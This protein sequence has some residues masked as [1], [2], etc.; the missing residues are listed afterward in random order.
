MHPDYPTVTIEI[1][2]VGP[3]PEEDPEEAILLDLLNASRPKTVRIAA[4]RKMLGAM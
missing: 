1:S 3:E 4:V 2:G